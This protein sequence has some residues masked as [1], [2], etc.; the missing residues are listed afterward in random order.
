MPSFEALPTDPILRTALLQKLDQYTAAEYLG[1]VANR[2]FW[3]FALLANRYSVTQTRHVLADKVE[4]IQLTFAGVYQI[5]GIETATG[6][7]RTITASISEDANFTNPI[8]VTFS[9]SASGTCLQTALLSSDFVNIP[10]SLQKPGAVLY[11][12]TWQDAGVGGSLPYAFMQG[13]SID[14]ARGE[15]TKTSYSSALTDYTMVSGPIPDVGTNR[16]Q[17]WMGPVM[18]RGY[19]RK[20][21]FTLYGDSRIFG[22]NC[23]PSKSGGL[24]PY[25]LAL[26]SLGLAYTVAAVPGDRASWFAA[27]SRPQQISLASSTS[28][29]I[30]AFGGNDL[31]NGDSSAT[32]YANMLLGL[33]KLPESLVV[34]PANVGIHNVSSSDAYTSLKGQ[35]FTTANRSEDLI[36]RTYNIALSSFPRSIDYASLIEQETWWR[37]GLSPSTTDGSHES[38]AIANTIAPDLA[39]LIANRV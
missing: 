15:V 18:I 9:G 31:S 17:G 7:D 3:P 32:L 38:S 5:N 8:Q 12:R 35:Y 36:R 19:T 23:F 10:A 2:T 1:P 39:T 14:S 13:S 21:T 20:P 24:S 29:A 11:V 30:W 27:N 33:A 22:L 34:L 6:F 4:K 28:H 16:T 37:L 25:Q 26:D